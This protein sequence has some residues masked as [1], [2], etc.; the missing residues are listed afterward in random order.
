M[1]PDAPYT[2]SKLS[3]NFTAEGMTLATKPGAEVVLR[4]ALF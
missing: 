2:S 1:L 3:A 4:P